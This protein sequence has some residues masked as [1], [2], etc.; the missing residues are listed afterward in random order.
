MPLQ[1][2]GWGIT[3][4]PCTSVHTSHL[5]TD[6]LQVISFD[7]NFMKLGH[8]VK[9]HNLLIQDNDPYGTTPSGVIALCLWKFTIWNDVSSLW[10]IILIRILWNLVTSF[11]TNV[12]FKFKNGPYHTMPSG[13]IALCSWKFAIYMNL[14]K[15][16]VSLF[17]VHISSFYVEFYKGIIGKWPW[18]GHF[19]IISFVKLSLYNTVWFTYDTVHSYGPPD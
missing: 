2:N 19:P 7:Q 9:Y 18:I 3:C 11:I 10:W 8:I 1:R 13:V 12:F 16:G 14:A 5:L 15:V 4:Y 6:T 17:P